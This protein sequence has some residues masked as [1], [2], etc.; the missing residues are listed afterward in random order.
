MTSSVDLANS[1]S[2]AAATG[3]SSDGGNKNYS[4]GAPLSQQQ[5]KDQNQCYICGHKFLWRWLL[6]RHM[7][8][9]T[10]EKPYSCNFCD[11]KAARKE[12]VRNHVFNK[13]K[14]VFL[15]PPPSPSGSFM[16]DL[17]RINVII[18]ASLLIIVWTFSL[19]GTYSFFSAGL[20]DL[21]GRFFWMDWYWPSRNN[22]IPFFCFGIGFKLSSEELYFKWCQTVQLPRLQ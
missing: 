2:S 19:T 22:I 13:H 20:L 14:W 7:M 21:A 4:S 3:T 11:Y 12:Q 9:H 15:Y 18:V 5:Q 6:V 10:G 1:S 17:H 8:I 16:M